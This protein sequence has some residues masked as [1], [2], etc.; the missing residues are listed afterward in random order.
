MRAVLNRLVMT[1]ITL[2][3]VAV[4][5][6]SLLRVVPGDPVAMMVGPAASAADIAA[7]RAH[8]GLDGPLPLQFLTWLKAAVVGDFGT[9]ITRH[10]SVL[11]ILGAHL[12]ATIELAVCALLA[13]VLAAGVLLA[14]AA[15]TGV[16]PTPASSAPTT[17]IRAFIRASAWPQAAC[18]AAR[19][20]KRGNSSRWSDSFASSART[21]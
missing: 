2:F 14:A 11:A 21:M 1:V 16:R 17:A 9:S 7:L 12:P 13:C 19:R 15:A 3:G 20:G 10:Q 4:V 5:V 6:F 18:A 8:Y